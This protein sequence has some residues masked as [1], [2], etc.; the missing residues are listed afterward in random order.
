[1]VYVIPQVIFHPDWAAN[2]EETLDLADITAEVQQ[3]LIRMIEPYRQASAR[4]SA[5]PPGRRPVCG[6][7][8]S[9]VPDRRRAHCDWGARYSGS[10]ALPAGECGRKS[11]PR[12][13]VFCLDGAS[14][15]P[16][17]NVT[18]PRSKYGRPDAAYTRSWA[19]FRK[20]GPDKMSTRRYHAPG[21][22]TGEISRLQGE[23]RGLGLT[24][25]PTKDGNYGECHRT[26]GR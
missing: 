9:G 17:R 14:T 25:T 2:V 18:A 15:T 16:G 13:L 23:R 19:L 22:V 11:R 20:S 7:C 5:K 12:H 21:W 4:I 26:C 1:M 6:D 24:D 10:T 8:A 3:A